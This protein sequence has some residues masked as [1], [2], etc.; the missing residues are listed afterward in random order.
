MRHHSAVFHISASKKKP[1]FDEIL[2][3]MLAGTENEGES[4]K[5]KNQRRLVAAETSCPVLK[6]C[7]NSCCFLRT[8]MIKISSKKEILVDK[9]AASG[10]SD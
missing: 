8:K 2:G 9:S 1:T 6:P 4:H 7:D 3:C 10:T 5:R